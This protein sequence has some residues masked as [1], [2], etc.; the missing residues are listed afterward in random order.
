[1]RM[2]WCDMSLDLSITRLSFGMGAEFN[3]IEAIAVTEP[4]SF[5]IKVQLMSETTI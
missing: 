4:L 1:M 5:N 3:K 2:F